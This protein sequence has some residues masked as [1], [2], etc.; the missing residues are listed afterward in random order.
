MKKIKVGISGVNPFDGNRGVGALSYS[1]V[2]ILDDI[3]LEIGIEFE[4][5][6]IINGS[7]LPESCNLDINGVNRKVYL[8]PLISPYRPNHLAKLLLYSKSALP[9]YLALDYVMDAGYGDSYSDIYG[10]ANFLSHNSIK[11]FF[12]LIGKKQML[13]PQTVGPF[14]GDDVKKAAYKTLG[15]MQILLGRD[16]LSYELVKNNIPKVQSDEII[17]MA[18]FMPYTR[19]SFIK[20]NGNINVGIGISKMLWNKELDGV[21]SYKDNYRSLM[22]DVINNF[23]EMENVNVHL[24]PHV[25][26]ENNS[27]GNDYQ[28]CYELCKQ[29]NN[30]RLIL[31]PFFIDPI[32]AKNYI[33]AMDFFTGARMHACIGAFSSGVPVYP[34]AYSR[35]FTGLFNETLNYKHV[36]DLTTMSNSEILSKIIDAFQRREQLSSEIAKISDSTVKEKYNLLK[37]HLIKFINS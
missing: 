18:F 2:K 31:S 3:G 27:N 12:S 24:I 23:L 15:K 9:K 29:Y 10:K 22:L 26:C 7:G 5:Y 6:F 36:G 4:I 32:K 28:L 11:R 17:D 16:K 20:K 35:K 25:V 33:S 19:D 8:L 34:I 1:I 37:S 14:F 30:D 13:L 21:M